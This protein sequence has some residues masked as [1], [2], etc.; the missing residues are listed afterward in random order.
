MTT[1]NNR[2]AYSYR[3]DPAVPEFEDDGPV[4]FMD[5]ECSL[6]TRGA[7]IIC[8]LDR[9]KEF[10]ICP[11]QSGLGQAVLVHY[12][13]DPSDPDSWLYLADG[14]AHTS[15]DAMIKVGRRLGGVGH[16]MRVLSVFPRALQDWIYL[17]IARNRYRFPGRARM[18]ALPDPELRSRL[19]E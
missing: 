13:L 17:R 18:C 5:G 15:I 2:E 4:V 14:Q 19:V 12:R 10:K 16:V 8:K 7:R 3:H 9:R 1:L 6:C 11:T